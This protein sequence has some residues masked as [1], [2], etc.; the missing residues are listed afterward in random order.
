MTTLMMPLLMTKYI[1]TPYFVKNNICLF[2]FNLYSAHSK[3][4]GNL[5]VRHSVIH[6]R[7]NSRDIACLVAEFNAALCFD[8]VVKSESERNENILFSRVGIEPT[9][10]YVKIDYLIVLQII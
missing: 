8:T 7:P 5:V 4:K 2:N 1:S 9:T 10:S 6:F 3:L